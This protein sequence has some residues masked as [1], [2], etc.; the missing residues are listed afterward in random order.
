MEKWCQ[1]QWLES[2]GRKIGPTRIIPDTFSMLY[3]FGDLVTISAMKLF[4]Q[5]AGSVEIPIA[6]RTPSASC[7]RYRCTWSAGA[8]G[9]SYRPSAV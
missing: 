5:N 2:P 7:V 3:L 6:I 9:T 8:R 4:A 1:G